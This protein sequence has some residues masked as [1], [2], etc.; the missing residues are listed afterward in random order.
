MINKI[1]ID[2]NDYEIIIN[3]HVGIT[4]AGYRYFKN[5]I[6]GN[7]FSTFET[8]IDKIKDRVIDNI[9][10]YE[11]HYEKKQTNK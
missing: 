3:K 8:D 2:N 10:Y 1:K 6:F 5:G 7:F 9:K 4:T 11:K